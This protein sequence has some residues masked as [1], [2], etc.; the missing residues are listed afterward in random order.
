MKL[1]KELIEKLDSLWQEG[2]DHE[3]I[4]DY[5]R[6]MEF[7][8]IDDDTVNVYFDDDSYE[9]YKFGTDVNVRAFKVTREEVAIDG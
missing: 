6:A 8:V 3:I 4:F 2:G 7:E 9:D 1:T 5:S